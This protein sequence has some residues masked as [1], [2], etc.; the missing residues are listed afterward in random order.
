MK[1]YGKS[2]ITLAILTVITLLIKVFAGLANP[3]KNIVKYSEIKLDPLKQDVDINEVKK[4]IT[5]RQGKI[6]DIMD[7]K[8]EASMKDISEDLSDVSLRTLRRDL[9]VLVELGYVSRRGST[10]DSVYSKVI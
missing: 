8:K 2:I 4:S 1:K 7:D 5:F 3:K 9:N 10:K 6:L